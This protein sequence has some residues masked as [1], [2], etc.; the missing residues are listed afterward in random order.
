M[1]SESIWI[2]VAELRSRV[3]SAMLLFDWRQKIVSLLSSSIESEDANLPNVGAGQDVEN[4]E[5]EFYAEALKA[6]GEGKFLLW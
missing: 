1:K 6:Q 3:I 4:P 2:L 5:A